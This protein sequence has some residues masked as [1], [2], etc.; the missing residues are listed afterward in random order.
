MNK[1][2][3]II[4]LL[5]LSITSKSQVLISLLLGDKLNSEGLEFGM[6]GGVNWSGISDLETSKRLLSINLGF[7]FDIRIKNQLNLYTGVLVKSNVGMNK[8]E[9]ADLIFLG[10]EIYPEPG[11]YKQVVNK[12]MIPAL[13]QYKFKNRFYI[14]VGPQIGLI[15]GGRVEFNAEEG[16]KIIKIKEDNN[17]MLNKF[18]AGLSGGF[19]YK[20]MKGNGLT[21]GL[22]YY[23]GFA[24]IYKDRS[25]TT[26]HSLNLKVNI[27]VGANKKEQK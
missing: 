12:F 17:E 5:L 3:L 13:L 23:Q 25:G 1:Y 7:Y 19:G 15:H 2:I 9:M 24:D 21:V 4:G 18:D 10:S 11:E 20:L 14:E 22:R 27:P 16:D 8:L 26:N 6:E